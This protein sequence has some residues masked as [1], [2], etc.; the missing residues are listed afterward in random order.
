MREARGGLPRWLLAPDADAV[1]RHQA[2][3]MAVLRVL[4][5]LMWLY[6]VS[7]KVPPGFGRSSGSGLYRYTRDAVTHPVLP[8]Y[9]WLVEHLVLPH[10]AVFGWLVLVVETALGVLL[11]SGSFVRL[12]ALLGIAQS[13][14]IGLSVA[15]APNEWPWSYWLMVGA[16]LAL[17]VGSSG[18]VFANDARRAGLAPAT[19]QQLA[20]GVVA[21]VVGLYS[22]V[23]SLGDPLDPTGPGLRS[24]DLSVSLGT[25]DLL[26]GL[27]VVLVGAGLLLA[28]R[29]SRAAALAAVGLAV[30]G[31]V[32]LTAQVGF[33]DPLLGGNATSTALLL[34]LAVV[35]LPITN[36]PVETS[37]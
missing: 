23:A 9:S 26:G 21:L 20:W 11:L 17:L 10:F 7:W 30:L 5:G 22:A 12:A 19:R 15:Y 27:V 24:S 14:A 6:N 2:V 1:P 13:L 16:H 29:G 28:S 37:R 4:L 25:Y 34:T 32:L 35:A 18:R 8:P 36:H 33:S 3:G 31:A